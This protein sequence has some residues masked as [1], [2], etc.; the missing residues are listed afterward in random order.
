[1]PKL[2]SIIHLMKP[3]DFE[4][5]L[6]GLNHSMKVTPESVG[7]VVDPVKETSIITTFDKDGGTVSVMKL[8]RKGTVLVK[9]KL[10]HKA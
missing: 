4:K 9:G 3:E 7:V 1:M 2:I 8:G 10:M 5:V 6:D